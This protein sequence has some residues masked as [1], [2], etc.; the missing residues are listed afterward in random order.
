MDSLET[1][2]LLSLHTVLLF[3][4]SVLSVLALRKVQVERE[5]NPSKTPKPVFASYGKE[6]LDRLPYKNIMF[7]HSVASWYFTMVGISY[8][9]PALSNKWKK[10]KYYSLYLLNCKHSNSQKLCQIKFFSS[11]TCGEFLLTIESFALPMAWHKEMQFC[12]KQTYLQF[13]FNF[14]P[15][16]SPWSSEEAPSVRCETEKGSKNWEIHSRNC[17]QMQEL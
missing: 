10:P 2:F 6:M 12:F 11:F 17:C 16:W 8:F 9:Y 1:Y 5:K 3:T 4:I 14:M 7:F 13:F 15:Q